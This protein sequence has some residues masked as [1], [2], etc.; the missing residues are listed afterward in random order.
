[1]DL[2]SGDLDCLLEMPPA[3]HDFLTERISNSAADAKWLAGIDLSPLA[4]IEEIEGPFG[5]IDDRR[6]KS[7]RQIAA[8][9]AHCMPAD[10]TL[11]T[12]AL[13]PSVLARPWCGWPFKGLGSLTP[14]RPIWRN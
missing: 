11:R 14:A 4:N 10:L 7:N 9:T 3:D 8:A 12:E 5:Y 6:R 2:S 1:M 13:K